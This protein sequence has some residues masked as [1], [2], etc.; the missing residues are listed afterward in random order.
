MGNPL[1][2]KKYCINIYGKELISYCTWYGINIEMITPFKKQQSAVNYRWCF[3]GLLLRLLQLV[4]AGS[5][6]DM[7]FA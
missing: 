1:K 2:Y 4:F 5:A 6:E 3:N 7:T